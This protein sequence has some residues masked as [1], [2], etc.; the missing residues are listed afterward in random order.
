MKIDKPKLVVQ[1]SMSVVAASLI[2]MEYGL[3]TG[4]AIWIIVDLFLPSC[5]IKE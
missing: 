4:V 5:I 2:G 3:A 1:L